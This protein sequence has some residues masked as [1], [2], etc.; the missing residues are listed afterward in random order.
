MLSY[1]PAAFHVVALLSRKGDSCKTTLAA[2]LAVQ[3]AAD[4]RRV[5]LTP[6]YQPPERRCRIRA[7][8]CIRICCEG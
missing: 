8:G 4:G 2:H 7:T 3:F 5:G 6:I 1:S